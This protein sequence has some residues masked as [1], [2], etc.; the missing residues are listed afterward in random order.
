MENI[1]N[2]K[3]WNKLKNHDYIQLRVIRKCRIAK[4]SIKI[5]WKCRKI[6]QYFVKNVEYVEY[7]IQFLE[8]V[9]LCVI[10]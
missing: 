4:N 8:N 10:M 7:V 6:I 2:Y 5:Y 3:K 9:E 1:K